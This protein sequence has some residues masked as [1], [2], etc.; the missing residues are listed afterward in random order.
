MGI[1]DFFKKKKN[2][3]GKLNR[4]Y[5]ILENIRDNLS[6]ITDPEKGDLYNYN[7]W[8]DVVK[9]RV[10]N[11]EN[12]LVNI[13]INDQLA[14]AKSHYDEYHFRMIEELD[15][16]KLDF[17]IPR[18]KCFLEVYNQILSIDKTTLDKKDLKLLKNF[19]FHSKTS[20]YGSVIFLF[21]DVKIGESILN[22]IFPEYDKKFLNFNSD[23]KLFT[24]L[25]KTIIET[26]K[27]ILKP[28]VI[29]YFNRI[30]KDPSEI[31]IYD[32]KT[33]SY[34]SLITM[35]DTMFPFDSNFET[36]DPENLIFYDDEKDYIDKNFLI[37]IHFSENNKWNEY[38]DYIHFVKL[39]LMSKVIFKELNKEESLD[40]FLKRWKDHIQ[41][42]KEEVI[43]DVQNGEFSFCDDE[44]KLTVG[45]GN[46]NL[47]FNISWKN[48][49]N[50]YNYINELYPD[51]FY[52]LNQ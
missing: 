40:D 2:P 37:L 44:F 23:K 30:L 27:E 51:E 31:F 18:I 8:F 7:Y 6:L 52:L 11:H 15:A 49:E 33:S 10:K 3:S 34:D 19:I 45:D 5:D 9:D 12:S 17:I 16:N 26:S 28:E 22:N 4:L 48:E 29:N 35:I 41:I 32:R 42:S 39:V 20:L 43:E 25:E 38:L 36:E 50:V 21:K 1:F 47:I 13:G 24:D 14:Y 46:S